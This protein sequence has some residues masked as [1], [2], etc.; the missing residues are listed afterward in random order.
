METLWANF[1]GSN[2]INYKAIYRNIKPPLPP[3]SCLSLH[4]HIWD[5]ATSVIREDKGEEK[6]KERKKGKE[7]RKEGTKEE[8]REEEFNKRENTNI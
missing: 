2:Q 3:K 6:R 1:S 5:L 8:E 7:R 4:M